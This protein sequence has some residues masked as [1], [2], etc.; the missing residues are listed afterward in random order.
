MRFGMVLLQP[1]WENDYFGAPAV[2]PWGTLSIIEQAM[3]LDDGRFN[4]LVRGEVRIRIVDEVS[5]D[6]YRMARVV[7]RP[8]H[9]RDHE[10]AYAQ[11]T[12]L[13]DLSRQYL[14]YLPEQ[15]A[16]PEIETVSLEPLTNALIMSLNLEVEEKQRLLEN[17]DLISRAEEVGNELQRRIES[18]Q[19]LGPYRRG[20]DPRW[21]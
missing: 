2:H 14:H 18:L 1:G 7:A 11:R 9:E 16:V 17:D 15:T 13:A 8:E 3:P 20:G 5:R 6:P 21:N 4:I 19:V 12:W 10:T